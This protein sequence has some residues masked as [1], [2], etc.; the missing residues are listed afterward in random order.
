MNWTGGRLQQSKRSGGPLNAKQ[1]AYFAKARSRLQDNSRTTTLSLSIFGDIELKRD[2]RARSRSPVT[3]QRPRKRQHTLEENDNAC[4]PV[5]KRQLRGTVDIES[6][7]KDLLQRSDWLGLAPTRPFT[8]AFPTGRGQERVGR[9]RRLNTDDLARQEKQKRESIVQQHRNP[10]MDFRS[11]ERARRTPAQ[12]DK[13]SVRFGTSIH[14]SQWTQLPPR[15]SLMEENV[16]LENKN[17]D[18]MLFNSSTPSDKSR[19]FLLGS[20]VDQSSVQDNEGEGHTLTT[21][22]NAETFAQAD[23]SRRTEQYHRSDDAEMLLERRDS[24]TSVLA[25]AS[26]L[27]D[28]ARDRGTETRQMKS[29]RGKESI[30]SPLRAFR[31][32]TSDEILDHTLASHDRSSGLIER[33]SSAPTRSV[34][35]VQTHSD[36]EPSL[37]RQDHST[38]NIQTNDPNGR[39]D[40]LDLARNQKKKPASH[41]I[42]SPPANEHR[43]QTLKLPQE[44]PS[45]KAPA[46]TPIPPSLDDDNAAWFRF[47]Y[48][49]PLEPPRDLEKVV[50]PELSSALRQTLPSSLQ[51]PASSTSATPPSPNPSSILVPR[52]S[53]PSS[54]MLANNPSSSTKLES[55][56]PQ[57]PQASSAD[58]FENLFSPERNGLRNIEVASNTA[59]IGTPSAKNSVIV[60]RKP[61][62]LE[63]RGDATTGTVRLGSGFKGERRIYKEKRKK[64]DRRKSKEGNVWDI[65]ESEEEEIED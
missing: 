12:E 2:P 27:S 48:G 39:E 44:E 30:E 28:S 37:P 25:Q 29:A 55:V 16:S 34:H 26:K 61:R 63:G 11:R 20:Q 54:S 21:R 22:T 56:V 13:I 45:L 57:Q 7:R 15:D 50:D 31:V 42:S 65:E 53:S 10:D 41:S 32:Q 1:K 51:V 6:R 17:S 4:P 38:Q 9:R 36:T 58:S 33:A 14:G 3:S 35:L 40:H 18:E 62:R 8:M 5:A 64:Q 46:P 23:V 47:V 60:F 43:T 52:P 19:V 24:V 49:F 59:T